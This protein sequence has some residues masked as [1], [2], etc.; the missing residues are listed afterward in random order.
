MGIDGIQC[1]Q[2]FINFLR[3]TSLKSYVGAI[4]LQ[5][6]LDGEWKFSLAK[7]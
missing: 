4:N 1:H 6:T 3:N 7:I 2:F 5:M